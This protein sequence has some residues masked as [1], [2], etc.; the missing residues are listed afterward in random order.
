MTN[1][2]SFPAAVRR[3][4]SLLPSGGALPDEVWRK[5]RNFLLG[6]TWFHAVVIAL[7]GPLFG[8]RWEWNLQSFFRGETVLHAVGEGLIVAFFAALASWKGTSRSF[9]A[10]AI[11]FGLMSSSA[12]LVHLSGGYIELH[13]HFF[14]MLTFLALLQDWVPYT[15]AILFVALHHGVVGVLWP[16]EVFNHPA[17]FRAPWHWAGIHVFFIFWS[18]VGSV[19]AW[20]FTEVAAAKIKPQ[21]NE[22]EELNKLQGDFVAMV[23]HDLRSPLT[24]VISSAA[25]M[26]DGL[27]GNV[28]EEQKK[29]L[30]TIETSSRNMVALVN[31]FLDI[32]K[33]EAGRIDLVK[34]KIDLYQFIRENLENYIPLAKSKNIF[35]VSRTDPALPRVCADPRRLEQV[36]A[37]LLSNAIKFT[38][39]G[40]EIEVGAR[41]EDEKEMRMWVRD[42]GV[43]ISQHEIGE[44]FDKY[45]QTKS[46][47]L[48]AQKGSGLGLAICKMIVEAHGRK[49][50]AESQPGKGST[51]TVS[52]P[53]IEG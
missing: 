27:L 6:L 16:E 21:A 2:I 9:Q 46:G 42:A 22:L 40:K 29:W 19:I 33:M 26:G 39:Q 1:R 3:L 8:Y 13:F 5:R 36:L 4:L 24:N 23:A 32:S 30:A 45:R 37:N 47:K 10:S 52:I 38:P 11:A 48:S 44:L 17:A 15:L 25:M 43:G 41:L 14:V 50:W 34:E 12:I 51:F 7:V 31:D 18:C 35:L 53:R 49:I 28:T 20:R